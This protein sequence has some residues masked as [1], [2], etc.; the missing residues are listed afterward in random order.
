MKK[1]RILNIVLIL[2]FCFADVS[3]AASNSIG[4]AKKTI[5]IN[6][7]NKIVNVVTVDLNSPDMI[8]PQYEYE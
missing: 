7:Q 5:K 2:V 8:K 3:L 4:V 6:N 1:N